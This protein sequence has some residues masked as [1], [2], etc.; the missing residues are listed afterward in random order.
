MGTSML[1]SK[2][3]LTEDKDNA[4][5]FLKSIAYDVKMKGKS[6]SF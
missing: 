5:Y 2:R 3:F 6:S 1:Y 4:N